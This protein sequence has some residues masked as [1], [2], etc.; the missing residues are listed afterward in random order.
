MGL[1]AEDC[2]RWPLLG[3]VI[4]GMT[5]VDHVAGGSWMREHEGALGHG[6]RAA[7]LAQAPGGGAVNEPF[8]A[9]VLYYKYTYLGVWGP[10]EGPWGQY[11]ASKCVI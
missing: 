11:K 9:L 5:H 7:Y 3:A 2:L 6:H 4:H 8:T 1:E 10:S